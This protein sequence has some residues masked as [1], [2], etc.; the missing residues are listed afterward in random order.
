[1]RA[2]ATAASHPACPA[3]TTTTSNCSVKD[4][5]RLAS[6][7][8]AACRRAG[9]RG[10]PGARI[11]VATLT[12]RAIMTTE[13]FLRQLDLR[14]APF[15]LLCHPFY[16]AWSAGELSRED[17]RE[18]ARDY[19]H[20]VKAFPSYLDEF[21]SR[22]TEEQLRRVVLVNRDDEMGTDNGSRSHA[23]LWLDFVEGMG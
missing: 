8:A 14:I 21:A 18:Y 13:D 19:Y 2:A 1:M 16:Q 10:G 9:L 11:F 3:P 20:H 4:G 6:I 23:E 17:L 22:L 7:L 5:M 12:M 15:D